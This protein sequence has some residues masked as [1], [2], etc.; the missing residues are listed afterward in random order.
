VTTSVVPPDARFV[1]TGPVPPDGLPTGTDGALEPMTSDGGV[2][3]ARQGIYDRDGRV[4]GYELLFRL[5]PATQ[6]PALTTEAEH[7][8]ATTEVIRAVLDPESPAALGDGLLLFV[9]VPRAFVVGA[10]PLSLPP[11]R[12]VIEVLEHVVPDD[13]L[14]EGVRVLRRRGFQ[15]AVDDWAGEQERHGLIAAAHY[16]KIDMHQVPDGTLEGVVQDARGT[17]PDVRVVVERVESAA[18][19][20]VALRSGA[21][22]FQGYHLQAP[23]YLPVG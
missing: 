22:L 2:G 7:E 12:V 18:D 23:E 17:S 16:V 20:D 19:L 1:L 5:P 14:L 15:V 3:V 21:D 6:A 11:E 8:R 9:N 10:L 13:E 4:V